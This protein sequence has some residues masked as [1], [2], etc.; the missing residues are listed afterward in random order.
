MPPSAERDENSE[1]IRFSLGRAL[2]RAGQHE[3]AE[4]H[5]ARARAWIE[6]HQPN[7]I[8]QALDVRIWHGRCL[9]DLQRQDP[10]R[11]CL[12]AVHGLLAGR[13]DDPRLAQ[14]SQW[15]NELDRDR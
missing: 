15:L 6:E 2:Q 8:G 11:S 5:L 3:Q 9:M 10:A 13:A 1:V 4:P 12:Q 14:V 7:A